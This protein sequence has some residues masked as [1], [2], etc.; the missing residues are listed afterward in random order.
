MTVLAC[1]ADASTF[2]LGF[3]ES[4]DAAQ[5]PGILEV[6]TAASLANVQAHDVQRS[7]A[8]VGAASSKL[9]AQRLSMSGRLPDGSALVQHVLFFERGPRAYQATV[10]G[11]NPS[12][13]AVQTFF[14]GIRAPQ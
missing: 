10:V 6:L 3:V 4:A 9:P 7:S 1:T 2:A 13:E 8:S 11:K 14:S 5:S 12:S